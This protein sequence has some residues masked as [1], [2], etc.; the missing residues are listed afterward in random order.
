VILIT[1]FTFD[2][3]AQ[4]EQ[5][6]NV[7]GYYC[8]AGFHDVGGYT[9]DNKPRECDPDGIGGSSGGNDSEQGDDLHDPGGSGTS[10]LSIS[11]PGK[12]NGDCS[13]ESA[14]AAAGNLFRVWMQGEHPLTWVS[15]EPDGKIYKIQFTDNQYQKFKWGLPLQAGLPLQPTGSGCTSS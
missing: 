8:P 10:G 11:V 5:A 15:L 3:P 2:E 6:N 9:V 12:A 1:S 7:N 4:A 14:E 13:S